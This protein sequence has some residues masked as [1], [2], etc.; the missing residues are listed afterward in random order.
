[1]A[2]TTEADRTRLLLEEAAAL[3][4]GADEHLR[5]ALLKL[6]QWARTD[7]EKEIIIEVLDARTEAR[8]ASVT[9]AQLHPNPIQKGSS[10]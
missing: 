4:S 7:Y 8:R 9:I 6:S 10:R 2:A 1:M 5:C 3:L